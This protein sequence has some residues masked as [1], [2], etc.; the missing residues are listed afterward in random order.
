MHFYEPVSLHIMS[1]AQDSH[2]IANIKF[3]ESCQFKMY[4]SFSYVNLLDHRDLHL[5]FTYKMK[6]PVHP[7]ASMIN[8]S[9][10]IRSLGHP[11]LTFISLLYSSSSFHA[12]G[13][14]VCQHNYE[15]HNCDCIFDQIF[16]EF[17]RLRERQGHNRIKIQ[18]PCR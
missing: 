10:C 13:M 18:Q 8:H 11:G 16:F 4:T 9:T 6:N 15:W 12:A 5:S 3:P 17:F 7:F 14:L 2:T 1:A